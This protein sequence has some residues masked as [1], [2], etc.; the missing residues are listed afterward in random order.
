MFQV[1]EHEQEL[2]VA[3]VAAERDDA[4]SPV[5]SRRLS[6]CAT[7]VPARAGSRTDANGTQ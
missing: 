6:A 1:V 5:S 2:L 7:A 3:E 4:G